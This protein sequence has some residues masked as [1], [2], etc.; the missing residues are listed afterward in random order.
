LQ[1]IFHIGIKIY[2]HLP[3]HGPPKYKIGI[4]GMKNKPSGNPEAVELTLT[5]V[6][7]A[8]ASSRADV[9]AIA[10]DADSMASLC[11]SGFSLVIK[12]SSSPFDVVQR[13]Q[14]NVKRVRLL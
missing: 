4:F 2:Q 10:T 7:V 3:F 11:P 8:G 1:L 6:S 13:L 9:G 14:K 12:S 5:T